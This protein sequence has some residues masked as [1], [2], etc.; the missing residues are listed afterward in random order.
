M[1]IESITL[2]NF[3]CFGDQKTVVGLQ[4]GITVFVG[5]NGSGKTAILQAL[6]RL[7]GVSAGQRLVRR[8][9]FHLSP[10]QTT[11]TSGSSLSIEVVF[12]FP[13]LQNSDDSTETDAVPEFFLQMAS[14]GQGMPLIAKLK[15]RA[16]WIDDGTP[17]G[18][19]EE[20]IRW[21]KTLAEAYVWEDCPKV[22]SVDRGS[23]QLIYLPATRDAPAQVTS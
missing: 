19:I 23:I 1:K 16:T 14:S 22:Q 10:E 6:S 5:G 2:E 12:S 15:L 9:D 21:I 8:R 4:Q 7:F 20:D 18:V 11:L 3:R 17:D 13:E